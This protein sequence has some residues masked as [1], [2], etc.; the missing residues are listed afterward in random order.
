MAK[1]ANS[2][3][4]GQAVMQ[5]ATCE[6][7]RQHQR[8]P[9]VVLYYAEGK[10]AH[11]S[12]RLIGCTH[13]SRARRF[14]RQRRRVGR[15]Q[16]PEPARAL[17][18]FQRTGRARPTFI[19]SDEALCMKR[20]KFISA[21]PVAILLAQRTSAVT[22]QARKKGVILMNR[23]GPSSCK[24]YTA[25]A[26]GSDERKPLHNAMPLHIPAKVY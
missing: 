1:D 11:A 18:A 3:S 12:P 10:G 16:I 14:D 21:V 13:V 20:R 25:N 5:S 7:Y 15:W 6:S 19:R 22:A 17:G 24:L 8:L 26:H 4:V 9:W 2:I 23:I